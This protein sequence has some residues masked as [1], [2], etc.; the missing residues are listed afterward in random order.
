[1]PPGATPPSWA[2]PWS[3][4]ACSSSSRR[5]PT[6]PGGRQRWRLPQE[7]SRP[8]RRSAALHRLCWWSTARPRARGTAPS[9]CRSASGPAGSSPRPPWSTREAAVRTARST[10]TPSRSSRPRRCR[11]SPRTWTRSPAPPTPRTATSAP[12]K[13]P[14]MPRTCTPDPTLTPSEGA[15]T[16]LASK[17]TTPSAPPSSRDAVFPALTGLV[18]FVVLLQFVFAGVFLRYDGERDASSGW[19]DAHAWGAHTGTLLAVIAAGYAIARLRHRKDLLYGSIALA[20]L[21]VVEAF[22]GGQIRDAGK[23]SWTAIHVPI[24]FLLTG[25]VIWLPLRARK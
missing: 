2:R 16:D 25:L 7:S 17:T 10:A 22:I 23:D 18:A 9:R 1:M 12:C 8:H 15:M 20:V 4:S 13:R 24:A 5:A 3:R 21:F 19:I 11:R 14:W 6:A